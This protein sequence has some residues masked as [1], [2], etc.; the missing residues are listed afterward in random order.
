MTCSS[1][2]R[3][4]EGGQAKSPIQAAPRPDPGVDRY[5]TPEMQAS[6]VILTNSRGVL[7]AVSGA[8]GML[9]LRYLQGA[10]APAKPGQESWRSLVSKGWKPDR[11]ALGM[12]ATVRRSFPEVQSLRHEG[13][14]NSQGCISHPA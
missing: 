7:Q 10:A 2:S 4:S 12:G 3:Q 5:V 11:G 6:R 9:M 13:H 14:W 1:V 8:R